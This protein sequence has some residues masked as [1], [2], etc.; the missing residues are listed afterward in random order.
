[1]RKIKALIDKGWAIDLRKQSGDNWFNVGAN[2]NTW[3][4]VDIWDE[5]LSKAIGRVYEDAKKLEL[6]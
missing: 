4:Y 2:H 1:M 3:G 6:E 5:N